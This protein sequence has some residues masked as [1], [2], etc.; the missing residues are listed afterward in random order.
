MS[1]GALLLLAAGGPLF[2]VH[3]SAVSSNGDGGAI[4]ASIAYQNDGDIQTDTTDGSLDV[5][6]WISP[7]A[8]A[9]GAYTI[10]V[11]VD[12]GTLD[13]GDS[14]DADLALST[15]RSWG[16]SQAA[17]G[18]KSATITVTIKD[19]GGNTVASGQVTLSATRNS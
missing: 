5:G 7:K 2:K 16:I 1:G 19:A 17:V 18:S 4:T 15:T 3:T 11:H 14:V 8:L 10:R 6:D 13:S 9:P 12:S